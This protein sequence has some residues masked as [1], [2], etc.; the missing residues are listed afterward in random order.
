MQAQ[1]VKNKFEGLSQV[2]QAKIYINKN[3]NEVPLNS[4]RANFREDVAEQLINYEEGISTSIHGGGK[5]VLLLSEE[6]EKIEEKYG[7]KE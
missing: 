7:G 4:L 1:T 3:G 2:V 6:S 5:H